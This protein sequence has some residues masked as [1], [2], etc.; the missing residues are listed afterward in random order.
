[1]KPEEPNITPEA[2][3]YNLQWR[4]SL[5]NKQHHDMGEWT[6]KNTMLYPPQKEGEPPRPYE[7]YWGR[8]NVAHQIRPMHRLA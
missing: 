5:S 3:Y 1:M 6:K 4:A 7:V 8:A 2:R